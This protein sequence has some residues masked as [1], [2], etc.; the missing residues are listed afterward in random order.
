MEH[1][2]NFIKKANKKH[3]YKFNY[4]KFN[5]V[6]AKTK[7]III[8]PEHGEFEQNPDKHL[9]SVHAC[10]LCEKLYKIKSYKKGIPNEKSKISAEEF[11]NRFYKKFDR[12]YKLILDNYSGITGNNISVICPE[13]G[14]TTFYPNNIRI[15]KSPCN[16]CS[17]LSRIKNTT[18]SYYTVIKSL[19]QKYNN[20]YTYPEENYKIYK[21]KSS[22]IVIICPEHGEYIKS[23]QK[24][25]SGQECFHCRIEKLIK[26]GKLSGGYSAEYFQNNPEKVH[27]SSILYYVKVGSYY[28][29]GITTNL[30]KRIRN[31]K[32]ES[33]KDVDILLTK[34]YTLQQSYIIEQEILNKFYE[35]RIFRRW[36]TELFDIDIKDQI[37]NYF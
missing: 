31:I 19:K 20:K 18:E 37:L 23:A 16:T 30:D 29:I 24:H 12:K 8:C 34:E 1:K 11:E 7:S 26:T 10:K 3:N 35:N 27:L 36:S 17:N 28:K 9:N 4:S 5:Y 15:I 2:E 25:L 33:K 22:K 32:S 21:N 13:H 14:E 6:N